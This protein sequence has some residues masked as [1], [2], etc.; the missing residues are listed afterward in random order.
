MYLVCHSPRTLSLGDG[1]DE[2]SGSEPGRVSMDSCF[3]SPIVCIKVKVGHQAG[4]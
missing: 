2:V 4:R 3:E 1:L